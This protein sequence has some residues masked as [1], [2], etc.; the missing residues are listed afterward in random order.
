MC[1]ATVD[2]NRSWVPGPNS[3]GELLRIAG[4]ILVVWCTMAVNKSIIS[5]GSPLSWAF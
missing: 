2:H 1:F 5:L 4:E 3:P